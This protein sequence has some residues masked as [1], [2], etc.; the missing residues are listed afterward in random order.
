[1]AV[2]QEGTS[3]VTFWTEI[4]SSAQCREIVDQ[5]KACHLVIK[6][7]ALRI[8]FC[9]LCDCY[10]YNVRFTLVSLLRTHTNRSAGTWARIR[11]IIT[12]V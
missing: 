9:S 4:L 5:L 12:C 10:C 11:S 7:A 8:Q 2:D 6:D 3:Q 1:M